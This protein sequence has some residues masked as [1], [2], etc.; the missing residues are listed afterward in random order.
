MK[1]LL[2]TLLLF[3]FIT[4]S[5]SQTFGNEWIN[6]NYSYF[7]FPI[8]QDG[9]YKIDYATLQANG[10][11]LTGYSSSRIQLHGRGEE[12]PLMM[13]DGGD[14]SFDPGD[15]FLFIAKGNDGWLDKTI[16]P[17]PA[18]LANPGYSLISDTVFYYYTWG[19][20]IQGKRFSLTNDPN[21]NSYAPVN[22]VEK[23]I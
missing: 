15:Y 20:G 19:S 8:A 11:P 1:I 9:I 3:S 17:N 2:T 4:S 6:Y 5:Q 23:T 22:Y 10:V 7:A 21:Y 18:K 14:N 13:I 16:V 12:I